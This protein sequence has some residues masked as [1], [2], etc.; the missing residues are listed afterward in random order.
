MKLLCFI[1]LHKWTHP[2]GKCLRCS[3]WPEDWRQEISV[4]IKDGRATI[5]SFE[6]PLPP[7]RKK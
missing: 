4:V 2:R 3:K 7:E 5:P 1:G 6:I